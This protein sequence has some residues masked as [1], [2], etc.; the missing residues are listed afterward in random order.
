MFNITRIKK[1]NNIQ[2]SGGKHTFT[3]NDTILI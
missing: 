2:F 3:I 1:E